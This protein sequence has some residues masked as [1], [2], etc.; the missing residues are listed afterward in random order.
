LG[1]EADD[2]DN[3]DNNGRSSG[4]AYT[5]NDFGLQTEIAEIHSIFPHLF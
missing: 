1:L 2:A 5:E 4:N 3:A